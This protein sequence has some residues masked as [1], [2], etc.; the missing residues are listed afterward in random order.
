MSTLQILRL[1]LS[2]ATNPAGVVMDRREGD[3]A[4][5]LVDGYELPV[6]AAGVNIRPGQSLTG[7]WPIDPEDLRRR[8]D[9]LVVE[10]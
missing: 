5:L 8:F 6:P 2:L 7:E 9:A 4:V 10:D 1:C 3:F